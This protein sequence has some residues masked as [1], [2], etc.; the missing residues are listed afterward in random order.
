MA[1]DKNAVHGFAKGFDV[2]LPC[3]EAGG[4]GG[5]FNADKFVLAFNDVGNIGERVAGGIAVQFKP[6]VFVYGYAACASSDGI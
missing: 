6:V 2:F 3:F 5:Q 1:A 4:E